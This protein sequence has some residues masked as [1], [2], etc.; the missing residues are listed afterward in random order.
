LRH[1]Y[2]TEIERKLERGKRVGE[3]EGGITFYETLIKIRAFKVEVKILGT[4]KGPNQINTTAELWQDFHHS[5][6]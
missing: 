6:R 2:G 4:I 3:G 1:K 5:L